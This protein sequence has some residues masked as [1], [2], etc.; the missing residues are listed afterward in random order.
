MQKDG[1][2]LNMKNIKGANVLFES[3]YIPKSFIPFKFVCKIKV[4]LNL[5]LANFGLGNFDFKYLAKC[6]IAPRLN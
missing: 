1:G 3:N 5:Y 6:P 4:S 2:K